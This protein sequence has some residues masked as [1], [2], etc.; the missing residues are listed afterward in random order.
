MCSTTSYH[1]TTNRGVV[2]DKVT[3][4]Y[5]LLDRS[6]IRCILK[7]GRLGYIYVRVGTPRECTSF[8][9]ELSL[10]LASG[11]NPKEC[12]KI[13]VGTLKNTQNCAWLHTDILV[14]PSDPCVPSKKKYIYIF[15]L[16]TKKT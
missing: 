3:F 1:Y 11:W 4:F 13:L 2:K 12:T 10:G 15:L 8:L 6:E 14:Y 5:F 7:V 9:V 16:I